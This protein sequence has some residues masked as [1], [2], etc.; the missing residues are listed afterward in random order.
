MNR[1]LF[2]TN[3]DAYSDKNYPDSLPFRPMIG[4]KVPFRGQEEYG[5]LPLL[6]ITSISYMLGH[7]G[8]VIGFKCNLYFGKEIHPEIAGKILNHEVR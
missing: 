4:D 1:V 5:R 2:T 6:T 8:E 3:I 7:H